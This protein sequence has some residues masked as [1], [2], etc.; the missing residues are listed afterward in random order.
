[1]TMTTPPLFDI[2]D[3]D[4]ADFGR[5]P[6]HNLEAEQSVLGAMLIS[7]SNR[8]ID[9]VA[10]I[11]RPDDF[12]R[13][14]HQM[15]ASAVYDLNAQ[16]EAADSVTVFDELVKRGELQRV[17]AGPYLHT[18][19]AATPTAANATYYANIVREQAKLRGLI[20]TGTRITE[21][22]YSGDAEDAD[23]LCERAVQELTRRDEGAD[24]VTLDALMPDLL[25]KLERG[26]TT[27]RIPLPYMDLDKMLGGLKAGQLVIIGA[28]P[29]VGKSVV[30][31]DI[32]RFAALKK[33]LP[34]YF[35]SLEMSREELGRRLLA[36]EG[37]VLL[38]HLE[39]NALTDTDWTQIS[40][41]HARLSENSNLVIDDT[42]NVTIE[43]LRAQLR[44]MARSATG[45]ARLLVVDYLQLMRPLLKAGKK[46]AENRQVEVSELSRDLKLLAKEFGI[47]VVVLA[48]LNRGVEQRQEK[49]PLISDLRESGS[50]EQDG[51]VVILLYRGEKPEDAGTLELIVGKN[52]NGPTGAVAVAFQGHYA[53]AADMARYDESPGPRGGPQLRAVPGGA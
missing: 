30:A 14:A 15:I 4:S 50:L 2:D 22:G 49:R 40:K 44:K 10:A 41:V 9:D 6:P 53:R 3:R 32:A 23:A 31:L 37:R 52:R 48:Q 20:E 18:L 33:D 24:V 26:D 7:T 28:R 39:N 12:Y 21:F 11:I 47:P 29:A 25:D 36:A 19:T 45:P 8:V 43:R 35:A 42:A 46:S 51:D 5:T 1:M 38:D 27:D 34:V 16:G 13:P 17:G